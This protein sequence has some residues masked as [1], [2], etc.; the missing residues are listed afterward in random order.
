M[1]TGQKTAASLLITV[2]VSS[3]LAAAFSAKIIPFV[4]TH[5]YR[6]TVVQNAAAHL[7]DIS[8]ALEEYTNKLR[9]TFSVFADSAAVK[10]SILP[11]AQQ[12]DIAERNRLARLLLAETDG[13]AGIAAA[14]DEGRICF[15]TFA[16]DAA[17]E[18]PSGANRAITEKRSEL[19]QKSP[20]PCS[21]FFDSEKN[22]QIYSVP[23]YDSY[24]GRNG[25]ALFYVGAAGFSRFLA[26]KMLIHISDAADIAA[27]GTK[28]AASASSAETP[29]DADSGTNARHAVYGTGGFVLGLS[30]EADT[31]IPQ[32]QKHWEENASAVSG[33]AYLNGAENGGRILVSDA[34]FPQG[35]VAQ[36]LPENMF[37]LSA[38]EKMLLSA[39]AFITLYLIVFLL[40]SIKPD[41][42][43]VIRR[44]IKKLQTAFLADYFERKDQ[45]NWEEISHSLELH[46]QELFAELKKSFRRKSK[47]DTERIDALLDR[48]WDDMLSVIKNAPHESAKQTENACEDIPVYPETIE[49]I[50]PIEET[51]PTSFNPKAFAETAPSE[52]IAAAFGASAEEPPKPQNTQAENTE[53]AAAAPA[54]TENV[55]LPES[56]PIIEKYPQMPKAEENGAFFAEAVS[57][58]CA[59]NAEEPQPNGTP[60]QSAFSDTAAQAMQSELQSAEREKQ[61]ESCGGDAAFTFTQET[62]AERGAV[63]KSDAHSFAAVG[64]VSA[65]PA[66]EAPAEQP[67][68][69][70]DEESAE[71]ITAVHDAVPFSFAVQFAQ[72][73]AADMLPAADENNAIIEKNGIFM[74]QDNL[75]ISDVLIDP[76][77][78]T[79]VDSILKN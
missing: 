10:H 32:I 38:A 26:D 36:I 11:E 39:A 9:Q 44:K 76:D 43:T 15:S 40:F 16:Q 77:F 65:Y 48:S 53:N 30:G 78:K 14:D 17:A 1:T 61:S 2:F 25:T 55:C 13:L 54:D 6:K 74:I 56:A 45:Y 60:R 3:A 27:L 34:S 29:S 46:K 23:F 41:D 57:G 64:N 35:I 51:N 52:Q 28:N 18:I 31:L 66:A 71:I 58:A 24:S 12:T 75:S 72:D 5:V 63:Q 67:Q 59:D 22:R 33:T 20:P 4:E 37:F 68:N 21:V 47:S 7:A 79:L 73:S 19:P 8:G 69:I 42:F 50:E 49:I 62:A 70:P